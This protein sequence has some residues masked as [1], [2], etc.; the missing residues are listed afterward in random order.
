M[1]RVGFCGSSP[2]NGQQLTRHI[3]QLLIPKTEFFH[4]LAVDLFISWE[5]SVSDE[6]NSGRGWY[7]V[8][9]WK[10]QFELLLSPNLLEFRGSS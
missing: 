10:T 3:Y 4:V 2:K 8:L 6:T 9:I 1:A 5:L 7:Q